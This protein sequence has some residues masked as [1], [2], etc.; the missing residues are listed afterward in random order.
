MAKILGNHAQTHK[1]S[2]CA[3]GA[4]QQALYLLGGGGVDLMSL[5]LVL[6]GCIRTRPLTSEKWEREEEL[7]A[8]ERIN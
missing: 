2:L 7:G 4:P 6:I 8:E 3:A 1:P 5:R